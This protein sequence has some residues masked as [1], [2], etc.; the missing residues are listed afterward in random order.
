MADPHASSHFSGQMDGARSLSTELQMHAS[1]FTA[2]VMEWHAHWGAGHVCTDQGAFNPNPF[3][4]LFC[5][6][7]LSTAI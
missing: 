7:T 6:M 3:T 5:L 2:V 4:P 1:F